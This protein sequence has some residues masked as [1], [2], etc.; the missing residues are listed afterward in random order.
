L[1]VVKLLLLLLSCG[2]LLKNGGFVK[3]EMALPLWPSPGV[4][5]CP[6]GSAF[7]GKTLQAKAAALK[8]AKE[9]NATTQFC[10]CSS[11]YLIL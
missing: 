6:G 11:F 5:A 3:V 9:F 4:P 7:F 8:Q 10:C 2:G 1:V